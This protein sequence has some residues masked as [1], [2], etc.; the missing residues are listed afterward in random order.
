[1]LP[2]VF[3]TA[4]GDGS[5]DPFPAVVQTMPIDPAAAGLLFQ[6]TSGVV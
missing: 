3:H 6:I 5:E 1:M 4:L 2:N